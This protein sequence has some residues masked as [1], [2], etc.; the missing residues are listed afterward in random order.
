MSG[1]A[2]CSGNRFKLP[3]L[4]SETSAEPVTLANAAQVTVSYVGQVRNT[5]DSPRTLGDVPQK[6]DG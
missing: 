5:H 3:G 2:L 4:R 1:E 6:L